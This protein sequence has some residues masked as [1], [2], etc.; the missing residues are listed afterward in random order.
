MSKI[1]YPNEDHPKALY[2]LWYFIMAFTVFFPI[3]DTDIWWHLASAR[4]SLEQGSFLKIDPFSY[5]PTRFDFWINGHWLFQY[6]LYLI[7]R[8]GGLPFIVL[9]KSLF[10]PIIV[11]LYWKALNI[12]RNASIWWMIPISWVSRYLILER[13]LLFSLFFLGI[14]FY[15]FEKWR[16]KKSTYMEW[17]MILIVFWLWVQFQGLFILGLIL[18]AIFALDRS[19][20]NLNKPMFLA[21]MMLMISLINPYGYRIYFY[22]YL[23][24]IRILPFSTNPFS[25]GVVENRPLW[26]LLSTEDVWHSVLFL[27]FFLIFIGIR[28][29]LNHTNRLIYMVFGF[30]SLIAQRNIPLLVVFFPILVVGFQS[31]S[32]PFSLSLRRFLI[33]LACALS[34]AHLREIRLYPD[35]WISPYRVPVR[36]SIW[37]KDNEPLK[38]SY[39]PDRYGSYLLW[40]IPGT[41]SFVDGRFVLKSAD[42]F[43]QYRDS[44]THDA[45]FTQLYVQYR[46]ERVILPLTYWDQFSSL[47]KRLYAL[48]EWEVVY[49]DLETII[50]DVKK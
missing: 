22:A 33:L 6:F 36:A 7:H 20:R 26:N 30:L 25:D 8:I 37:L 21:L 10:W 39:H 38:K 43:D 35:L 50:F 27:I 31:V 9:G 2:L 47:R 42:F 4:F 17:A 5:T 49:S 15:Y 44:W 12:E 16:K 23:L 24:F 13:P 14:F 29:R 28:S 45:V 19:W 41:K 18:L 3:T 46:F 48:E 1:N 11:I 34:F 40:S 32:F